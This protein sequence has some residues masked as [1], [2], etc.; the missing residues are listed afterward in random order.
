MQTSSRWFFGLLAL[1]VFTLTYLFQR[2]NTYCFFFAEN[3]DGYTAF[4]FNKSLRF[5]L[6][7]AACLLLVKII[8][9]E[10]K[11][12]RTAFWLF[13]IELAV[14]LPSYFILKLTMEGTSEISSPLLSQF[15]R[16]IINPTLMILLMFAFFYQNYVSNKA[17]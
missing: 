12:V 17:V 3:C 8:F 4:I 10:P 13:L 16:L 7:D 2:F 15:H 6:N 14:L 5:I 9:L 1:L 11:Y